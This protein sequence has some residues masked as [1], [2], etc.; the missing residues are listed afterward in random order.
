MCFTGRSIV[1]G[2]GVAGDDLPGE[3]LLLSLSDDTVDG[4]LPN[5]GEPA[6]ETLGDALGEA[7]G[8]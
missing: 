6:G 7:F 4:T 3:D 2:D 8:E 1:L 5:I